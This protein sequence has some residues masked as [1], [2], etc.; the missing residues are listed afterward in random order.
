VLLEKYKKLL[1]E[2]E[3]TENQLKNEL[4]SALAH[5]FVLEDA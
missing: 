4:G 2:I 5:H 1:N 3:A